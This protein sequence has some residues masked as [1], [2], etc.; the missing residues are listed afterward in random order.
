MITKQHN[1]E[2]ISRHQLPDRFHRLIDDHYNQLAHWLVQ[3]R[4]DKQALFLGISGAQ[5]TGKSTLA[6]FLQLA[7]EEGE[8]WHVAN[9]SIDDFYLTKSE[10]KRLSETV[11]PLLLTRGVP[12]THDLR[13]LSTC[14]EQL[15][16]LDSGKKLSL[17]RFSKAHDDRAA[18]DTWPAVTGP[19][20]LIILEG[21]CV[22][23]KPQAA[24]VLSQPVN[25]LEHERDLTGEWRHFVNERLE[26]D[27][28]D[29]FAEL[30][31]L[32][33][34]Q[35]PSFEV[36]YRWR[37][38]QEEKL[39]GKSSENRIGIMSPAE[40]VNFIQHY[41]RLT[42]ANLHSLPLTADIVLELDDN[43]DC[44]RKIIR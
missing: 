38:E 37:L 27:Y 10:R 4:R 17:P 33:F 29:L 26:K 20:D 24:D 31:I 36:V 16:H 7:L 42:R 18:A 32:L 30:D 6:D 8:G 21:W 14:I 41:E 11:H 40:I 35:A 43:H 44:V 39:A 22:G 19:I 13:L 2:F 34:L 28:V 25:K 12:G 15:R 3:Q 1:D 9:L 23:S 5:G